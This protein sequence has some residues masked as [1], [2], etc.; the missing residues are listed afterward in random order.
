MKIEMTRADRKRRK[1]SSPTL[2]ERMEEQGV[3]DSDRA[4]LRRFAAYLNDA[5]A[6]MPLIDQI[7]KHGADY[8][9][10]TAAEV[11]SIRPTREKTNG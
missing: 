3:S 2:D 10:F 5:H 1:L 11:E 4:E 8:L 9:G 7:E 6:G